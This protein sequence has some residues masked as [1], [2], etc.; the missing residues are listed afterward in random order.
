MGECKDAVVVSLNALVRMP[1]SR[2]DRNGAS[3]Q[4][5]PIGDYNSIEAGNNTDTG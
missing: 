5:E 3:A 1:P 2:S 4:I